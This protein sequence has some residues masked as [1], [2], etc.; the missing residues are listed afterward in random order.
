[1]S[2]IKDLLAVE[3]SIDDLMPVSK[4]SLNWVAKTTANWA[5]SPQS[6]DYIA[7]NAEFGLGDDD[8]HPCMFLENFITLCDELAEEYLNRLIEQEHIELSDQEYSKVLDKASALIA[9]FYS[10]Y[11]SALCNDELIDYNRDKKTFNE[12]YKERHGRC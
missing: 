3:E 6:E 7:D 10:D 12:E 2:R 8:G 5:M 4:L 9:D 1:M 11:E